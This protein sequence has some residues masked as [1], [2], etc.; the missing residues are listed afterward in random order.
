MPKALDRK[1]FYGKDFLQDGLNVTDNAIMVPFSHMVEAENVMVG[2]TWARRKR[3]GQAYWNTDGDDA[4]SSYPTNPKNNSNVDGPPIRGLIEFWRDESGTN[5]N[6]VMV[7]QENKVWSIDSRTSAAVDRTGAL[8]LATTGRMCFQPFIGDV[9]FCSTNDSDGFNKWDGS[10]PSATAV[11]GPVDGDPSFLTVYRNRLVGA[12]VPGFPYTVYFSDINDGNTWVIPGS[13]AVDQATSLLVDQYGD[14]DGVTGLCVFQNRL[15]VFLRRAIYVITGNDPTDFIVQPVA[16]GVGAINH[17]CIL[18]I[19]NDVYYLSERGLL[20]LSSTDKAIESEY[21]FMSRDISRLYH[22]SLDKSLESQWYMSYDERENLL[23]ISC[24]SLGS[25]TNDTMLVY[26]TEKT[27]WTTW[28]DVPARTMC[29]VLV[30]R[31]SRILAGRE[32]GVL[33][34]MGESSRTDLGDSYTASF[35]TG[36]YYPG[37]AA[38]EEHVFEQVT[39]LASAQTT[40]EIEVQV[41]IDSEIVQTETIELSNAG[42]LLGSTF[43]LGSSILSK[44]VFTPKT[45]KVNGRGFGIQ[46]RLSYTSNTDVEIYGFII[47]SRPAGQRRI[48]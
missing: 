5:T 14:P 17:H 13:P 41:S 30:D 36:V 10:S 40:G 6:D 45:F 1:A 29:N 26:N 44:G 35:L 46:I 4:T 2:S 18:P 23:Y 25:T 32:D 39:V 19:G 12:G 9:F 33:S 20:S 8:S 3:P 47:G 42:D 34:L 31:S 38:D 11:T 16:I 24:T 27:M 48:G 15:Y 28:K 22:D 7:A 43:T 21:G 37:M